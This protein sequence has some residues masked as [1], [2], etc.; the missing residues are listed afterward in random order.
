MFYKLF[1]IKQQ[2]DTNSTNFDEEIALLKT[3]ILKKYGIDMNVNIR[4]SRKYTMVTMLDKVQPVQGDWQTEFQFRTCGADNSGIFLKFI[5]LPKVKQRSGLGF[6]CVHWLE[7]FAQSHG[8]KHIIFSS[9]G[10][11]EG[12]WHKMGYDYCEDPQ[13][14]NKL[15]FG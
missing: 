3:N 12:F 15:Y 2:P 13:F 7:A 10:S 8:F 1:N 11:A 14:V 6:Y 4:R 9:Y 5:R